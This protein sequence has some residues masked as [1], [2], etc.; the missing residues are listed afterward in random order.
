MRA[1]KNVECGETLHVLGYALESHASEYSLEQPTPPT[2]QRQGELLD[3]CASS[4]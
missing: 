3:C 1:Y 4:N 2:M